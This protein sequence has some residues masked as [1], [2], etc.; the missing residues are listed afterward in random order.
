MQLSRA[1]KLFVKALISV[2]FFSVLL[3]F[4]QTNELAKVVKNINWLYMVITFG[5]TLTMVIS[6][7][8]F[9]FILVSIAS[10]AQLHL[11]KNQFHLPDKLTGLFFRFLHLF[12][13]KTGISSIEKL[14]GFLEKTYVKIIERLN[15]VRKELQVASRRSR[16]TTLSYTG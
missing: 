13:E 6:G 10:L 7:I 9:L 1:I 5:V 14:I 12:A 8:F 2:D 11:Y 16:K 3:S 4:V 15:G